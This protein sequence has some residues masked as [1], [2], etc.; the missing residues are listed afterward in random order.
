MQHLAAGI[1]SWTAPDFLTVGAGS[2]AVTLIPILFLARRR[3][4]CQAAAR[5]PVYPCSVLDSRHLVR[6]MEKDDPSHHELLVRFQYTVEGK[7]W[8]GDK[9]DFSP[10]SFPPQQADAIVEA[11]P[12][13]S[14]T[15]C[16]VD[17]AN[18]ARAVLRPGGFERVGSIYSLTLAFSA[19]AMAS[20]L[21]GLYLSLA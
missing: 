14:P 13:G 8:E 7:A 15:H 21:Y 18:P 2:L 3:Y 1:T 4:L 19:L 6:R 9:Y 10:G 5:W 11:M 20:L 17:P 12:A 16:H